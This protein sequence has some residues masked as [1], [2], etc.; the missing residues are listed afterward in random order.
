MR[1][2]LFLISGGFFAMKGVLCNEGGSFLWGGG[3][4]FFILRPFFAQAKKPLKGAL[5][6]ERGF[7]IYKGF[8]K[9]PFTRSCEEVSRVVYWVSQHGTQTKTQYIRTYYSYID[10]LPL[11][12]VQYYRP[13][14]FVSLFVPHRSCHRFDG[15]LLRVP[16]C[17]INGSSAQPMHCTEQLEGFRSLATV[18]L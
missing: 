15:L 17:I 16:T 13:P 8:L 7:F 12:P 2:R 11:L 1:E 10:F 14:C 6:Y 3:E 4:L 9:G 18:I 5:S